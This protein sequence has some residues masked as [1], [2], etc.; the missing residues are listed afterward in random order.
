MQNNEIKFGKQTIAEVFEDWYTIPS[1]QRNYVWESDHVFDF[2]KDMKDNYVEHAND[3]YFLGS[4]I[5]QVRGD[6]NDLLDGQQRITTLFLLFAFLRDYER[7]EDD[8]RAN[9]QEMIYQKENKVKKLPSRTRLD[10]Q[11]RGNVNDFIKKYIINEGS[12]TDN[13]DYLKETA[14]NVKENTTIRHMC[15]TLVC[16]RSYFEENADVDI[17]KLVQ[18]IST[19]VVVIY[20]SADSLEDAFRLFSIMNDRGLKLCSS[21]ILKSSNLEKVSDT[22]KIDSFARQWEEIQ[23]NLGDDIDR[24]LMYIRSMILK[25]R[26]KTNL[27]DEFEKNIFKPGIIKQGEAFFDLVH[28]IYEIY[29]KLIYLSG[30]T[31]VAY[32][33]LIRILDSSLQNTDWV[34]VIMTYYRKFGDKKLTDF[35]H[36]VVC[37][38][39]ADT[40]CGDAPST[41][42]DA[43][44]K[45]MVETSSAVSPDALMASPCFD[46]DKTKFEAEIQ[47][48]IYGKGYAKALLM[49]LEYKYQDNSLEK[50]F[51]QISIEHILPQTPDPNSN[52]LINFTEDE[53]VNYTHKIGNLI[54]I[55]RRKNSSLGNLEYQQKRQ[56][57]F[58]KNIGSFARSLKLYNDY[59]TQWTSVEYKQNQENV[60]K[61]LKDIFGI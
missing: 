11:I 7:T 41:R 43:L 12:I 35:T 57:Y 37:K 59:Q 28:E 49:L 51:K 4:Y 27:L 60:I 24:F 34:P 42:I 40:V 9:L 3:E 45:I 58:N 33:N 36:K 5:K 55:G 19:N 56:K 20:I 50:S 29:D 31:D 18:F 13:W 23:E 44:N 2:L 39:I 22:R 14:V 47:S 15:N 26:A 54:I 17:T 48:D 21:D 1:Y 52:W 8:L 53:R 32:C 16:F 10:Y 30:N 6:S 25:V 61:D 46:F 38:N